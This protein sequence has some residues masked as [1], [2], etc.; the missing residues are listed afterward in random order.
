VKS[1]W[2]WRT[3]AERRNRLLL[4]ALLLLAAIVLALLFR[5]VARTVIVLPLLYLV[6]LAGLLWRSIPQAL[7]WAIF[8]IVALR[9]AVGSL[10]VRR[11]RQEEQTRQEQMQNWGRARIWAKWVELAARGGYYQ[12]RTARYIAGLTVDAL[13]QREHIPVDLVEGELAAGRLDVPPRIRAF[14]LETLREAP[15]ARFA[16]L[17][18]WLRLLPRASSV[19][20]SP[21]EVVDFLELNPLPG[22]RR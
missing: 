9:V 16:W 6:W 2:F 19:R 12:Q 3:F 10:V 8:V 7:I 11:R 21:K 20:V 4:L 13:A 1:S 15:P 5:D 17:G 14:L 18:Q 22:D